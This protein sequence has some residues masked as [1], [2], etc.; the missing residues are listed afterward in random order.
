M[1]VLQD[2]PVELLQ[3]IFAFVQTEGPPTT[4][5]ACSAVSW[6]WRDIVLPQL[7]S[8]FNTRRTESFKDVVHFLSTHPHIAA[9]VKH[10]RLGRTGCICTLSDLR[11][12]RPNPEVDHQTAHALLKCLPA[13]QYLS[14]DCVRF[15]VTPNTNA[16]A[17]DCIRPYRLRWVSLDR[18]V[19]GADPTPLFR[20]LSL[21]DI[22]TFQVTC[23]EF[24]NEAGLQAETLHRTLRMQ[25][26]WLPELHSQWKT[27][28]L[29]RALQRRLE[30]G[31]VRGL[32]IVCD[33]R[34]SLENTGA[35]LRVVGRDLTSLK[36]RLS[37][38]VPHTSRKWWASLNLS[39]CTALETFHL[40]PFI[41]MTDRTGMPPGGVCADIARSLAPSVRTIILQ[42]Y[43]EEGGPKGGDN[44][45]LGKL[46]DVVMKN[47][48]KRLPE[49]DRVT[50]RFA[51]CK[52]AFEAWSAA[53]RKAMP[54][55][56]GAGILHVSRDG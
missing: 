21:C 42:L 25:R 34:Q 24:P 33:N 23:T 22:G 38:G 27:G 2:L 39:S 4:L 28:R 44:F 55:L 19:I 29:M 54:G 17:E 12:P 13:L 30:P 46:D 52:D 16:L 14:F 36:L 6:W 51:F 32:S 45:E 35:L 31:C 20:I 41:S 18:C 15:V 8:T 49:L 9:C 26:L 47:K 10:L 37:P 43:A 53:S 7:F 1:A 3:G 50:L 5:I 48:Q 40:L 56:D 11:K